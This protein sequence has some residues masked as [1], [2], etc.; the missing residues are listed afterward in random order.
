MQEAVHI[1]LPQTIRQLFCTILEWCNLSNLT[2]LFQEFKEK[3]TEDYQRLYNHQQEFSDKIKFAMLLLDIEQHLTERN[4]MLQN[5][6]FL[7]ITQELREMCTT[8]N[9]KFPT[10]QEQ[11][12][13]F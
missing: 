1:Q 5:Y 6:N 11:Q 9:D 3:M 13:P 7:N 10:C 2:A 8:I 4:M 12:L